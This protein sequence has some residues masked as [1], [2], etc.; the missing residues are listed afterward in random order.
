MQ[1]VH[2]WQGEWID[3]N[4]L[5]QR[6]ENLD[7]YISEATALKFPFESFIEAC[8]QLHCQLT[9]NQ[10]LYQHFYSI[11][12]ESGKVNETEIPAMLKAVV[13]FS[14][15]DHLLIKLKRELG[16]DTPFKIKRIN[17]KEN[18][19]E[20]WVP[21]GFLVHI[22][23]SNVFTVSILSL[24]EGLLTGNI[25]FLKTS[26]SDSLLP[27]YFYEQL[28]KFDISGILKNFIIIARI[29]SK[30]KNTIKKVLSFANVV[31]AWGSEE[32]IASISEL[33]PSSAKIVK[34]GHKISFAYISKE[35]LF[36]EQELENLAKDVC[37][38]EQQACSSPQNI[39]IETEDFN[40]LIKFSENFSQILNKVSKEIPRIE[41]EFAYQAEITNIITVA[42][43]EQALGLTKVI[44]AEDKSWRI[45]VDKRKGLRI[46]PLYRSVWIKPLLPDEIV[47][48][49]LPMSSYLQT[50]GLSCPIQRLA[51]LASL[52]FKCGALRINQVGKMLGNYIGEPHDGRYALTE[53]VKRVSVNYD[54]M[55]NN[56]SGFFE[57]IPSEKID[58][59]NYPI[60]T[61][62]EFQSR[63]IDKKFIDLVFKS[64]GSSGKP[65]FSTFTY[66][67]YHIQM[68]ASA[69]GLYAAG[70][71]PSADRV[72]NLLAAGE[73]Y[74]GFLSFF[75]IM[76][77][78]EVP[79]Y[80]MGILQDTKHIAELIVSEQVNTLISVPSY[81][82][83]IFKEN[84]EL[85]SKN[86][87]VKKIFYG[88][89][90]ITK[91]QQDYLKE[92]FGVEMIRSAVYGSND[93]G[94]LG[95]QCQYC[96]GGEHHLLS[97]IQQ[98]E[99]FKLDEDKPA[100]FGEIGR[101]TFTSK[102]R[103]G[104]QIIRYEIGD[105]GRFLDKKCECGRSDPLFELVGRTGDVFKAGGPFLNYKYFVKLLEKLFSYS[106]NIQIVLESKGV[107]IEII[108]LIDKT[109]EIEEEIIEKA[110][111]ENYD[112][113]NFSVFELNVR[114]IVRKI[115]QEDFV[116]VHHSGKLKHIIDN[117][118]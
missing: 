63:K 69:Y 99:I 55:L 7:T 11:V 13:S 36:N 29:S 50:V 23:P 14:A 117:R 113:L 80:P 114:F 116:Y 79:Q 65:T 102:R 5:L 52:F 82:I 62:A 92:M 61:K 89:E 88:G 8:E 57:F 2:F 76:E 1:K 16:T 47:T 34:W 85:L 31:S 115:S 43:A 81:I 46:S 18:V 100:E 38:I 97:L 104:Q 103:K 41:P 94:P 112:A 111:I 70:L 105:A 74:G 32:A 21:V 24:L 48:T 56:Y 25:N 15:K 54:Q 28:I 109:L 72:M 91:T 26:G 37:I 75:T 33:S 45:I 66:E 53:F 17:F 84:E 10:E 101:L 30:D 108:L 22:A 107:T 9:N 68:L 95:Y 40:E 78:L 60:L 44:E 118:M 87:V 106:G 27:Q 93:A 20:G 86:Q 83:K 67:D 73:L 58:V 12:R 35:N 64:G 19:F 6:I 59:S 90:H 39:F 71:D 110:L 51:D 4:E 42:K 77:Y 96:T 3:D 98:L 49:L